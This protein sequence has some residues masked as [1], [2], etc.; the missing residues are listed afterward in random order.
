MPRAI[1]APSRLGRRIEGA[2]LN[3]VI[4][5]KDIEMSTYDPPQE[6]KLMVTGRK[7][8]Y[9]DTLWFCGTGCPGTGSWVPRW[10]AL[11]KASFSLARA[12][13]HAIILCHGR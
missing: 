9:R 3:N 6:P 13:A 5:R 7:A 11:S 12:Q 1:K 4:T 2:H 8:A 10:G